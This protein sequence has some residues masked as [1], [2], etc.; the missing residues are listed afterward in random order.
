VFLDE[1]GDVDLQLQ[2]RLLKVLE[3]KQFGGWRYP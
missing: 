3:E 2:P 1:I